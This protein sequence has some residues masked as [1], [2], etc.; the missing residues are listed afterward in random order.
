[1]KKLITIT[2]LLS[3]TIV[4]LYAGKQGKEFVTPNQRCGELTCI[5][6]AVLG[7]LGPI[8]GGYQTS[9]VQ[10]GYKLFKPGE[11]CGPEHIITM[12]ELE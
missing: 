4:T 10:C 1:M 2:V 8:D 9:G 5:G 11:Q 7:R 6:L 12:E 3:T